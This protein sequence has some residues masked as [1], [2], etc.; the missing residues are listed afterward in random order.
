M[1][2]TILPLSFFLS[3]ML[4][5]GS[6]HSAYAL[7]DIG[8]S[9]LHPASPFYFLK[10]IRENLELKFAGTRKVVYIRRLEFATRRLREVKS[11]IKLGNFE[12]I[13]PT[14]ENY[15]SQLSA[16]PDQGM[17][18]KEVLQVIE[19]NLANH[20]EVLQQIYYQIE[21]P[22]AKMAIRS[23]VNRII[24]RED[25]PASARES[26]CNFLQKE[27]SASGL[28]STETAVLLERARKCREAMLKI[29]SN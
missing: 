5:L 10:T 2:I 21:N 7:E 14:L 28:N 24:Q 15:A 19:N 25:L 17:Q 13:I 26:V 12:L 23:A 4:F 20:L 16:L 22:K 6:C 11:L 9:R 27:A 18:E 3:A 8:Q 29:Y 1:R